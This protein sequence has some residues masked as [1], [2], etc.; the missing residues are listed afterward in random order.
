MVKNTV[1]QV[2]L[3]DL[4]TCLVPLSTHTHTHYAHQSDQG[5]INTLDIRQ[6]GDGSQLQTTKSTVD[7]SLGWLHK[8]ELELNQFEVSSTRKFQA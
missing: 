8:D 7:L 4:S 3:R 2:V 5:L 1:A 6:S